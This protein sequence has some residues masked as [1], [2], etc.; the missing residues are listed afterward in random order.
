ML[1]CVARPPCTPSHQASAKEGCAQWAAASPG[2]A[3]ERLCAAFVSKV[4][5]WGQTPLQGHR[6]TVLGAGAS[7]PSDL[8][9]V[10]GFLEVPTW[11]A[12]THGLCTGSGGLG[13]IPPPTSS[14]RRR[15]QPPRTRP[16]RPAWQKQQNHPH[17]QVLH[18]EGAA[19]PQAP[20]PLTS[21]GRQSRA[22][23]ATRGMSIC[24]W[25]RCGRSFTDSVAAITALSS[26]WLRSG[27]LR[28]QNPNVTYGSHT[29]FHPLRRTRR[30]PAAR[31]SISWGGPW[32][33]LTADWFCA[34]SLR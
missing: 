12:C 6:Q 3:L 34:A 14:G 15:H 17:P 25:S 26:V 31:V 23:V 24:F 21:L 13:K 28:A 9:S 5:R 32:A 30:V 18:T 20:P 2:S 29:S 16:W 11:G 1:H 4:K 8:I 22:N 7:V 19:A 33:A 27:S 10:E